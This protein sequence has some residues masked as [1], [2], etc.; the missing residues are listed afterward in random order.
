MV[1]GGKGEEGAGSGLRATPHP[2]GTDCGWLFDCRAGALHPSP[3]IARMKHE[4]T[5]GLNFD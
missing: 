4:V 3:Q 5:S 1:R 2:S